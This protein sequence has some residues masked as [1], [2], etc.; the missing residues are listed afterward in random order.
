MDENIVKVGEHRRIHVDILWR[1]VFISINVTVLCLLL[2]YSIAYLLAV[3]PT[4]Q[5]N[6]LI[7]LLLLPFW[8]SLLVRT[9]AWLVLLQ[10]EGLVNDLAISDRALRTSR[11]YFGVLECPLTSDV[12]PWSATPCRTG[13]GTGRRSR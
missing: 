6:L 3:L 4:R 8:T 11:G 5:S 2:G 9:T 10:N 7:L 1:T 12:S 13:P